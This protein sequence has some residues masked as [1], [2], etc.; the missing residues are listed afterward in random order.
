MVEVQQSKPHPSIFDQTEEGWVPTPMSSI[1]RILHNKNIPK[2]SSIIVWGN[3]SIN[4]P[5]KDSHWQLFNNAKLRPYWDTVSFFQRPYYHNEQTK[6]NVFFFQ[7]TITLSYTIKTC[8]MKLRQITL[9]KQLLNRQI[10]INPKAQ[11]S[12]SI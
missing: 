1:S 6:K 8:T 2:V 5:N 9:T 10:K 11:L 3:R 12:I 7:L 4:K